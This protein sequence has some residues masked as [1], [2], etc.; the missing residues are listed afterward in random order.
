MPSTRPIEEFFEN[1]NISDT[2]ASGLANF[3]KVFQ[4][5]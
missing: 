1:V 4:H 2:T 5:H 3:K